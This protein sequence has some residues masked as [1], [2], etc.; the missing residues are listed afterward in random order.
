MRI[1]Y[2]SQYFPPEVGA[3]QI[4]AYEMAHNWVRLGHQVTMIA[5]IPNHPSGIIP[6]AYRGMLYQRENLDGIDVIRV[7]VRTSPVKNFLN[8]MLF[9]ITYMLTASAAGL[10]IARDH[11]DL[12]YASS[13]PLF[14]GG[15]ALFLSWA[16]RIPLVFEVRDLWPESAVVL[17]E[18]SNPRAVAWATRLEEAC[19]K[20]AKKIVVVSQEI[21]QR[22][23][24]RN[25]R[26]DKII[27]IPN[28]SDTEL[29]EFNLSERERLK[30][31][32][33]L[34]NKFLALYAGNHG[35]AYA[36]ET[37]IEAARILESN[38][39]FH[40]LLV[41][42]G[43]KKA[44]LATMVQEYR[45]SNVTM[46]PEQSRE[47]I[48]A[49]FSAADVV[50]IPVRNVNLLMLPVKIFD[51]WAC[52]RP[53]ILSFEGEARQIMEA[54]QAGVFVPPEDPDAL[55]KSLLALKAAPEDRKRM[56]EKGRAYTVQHHSRKALAEKLIK[57]LEK[58]D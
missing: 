38:P 55:A 14:V 36:L 16:R 37:L 46:L 20:R 21:R 49:F 15:A 30:A 23:V 44:A 28:G 18:L 2:L 50:I 26:E 19:Y 31:E 25:V 58:L 41:G 6:P 1:L 34:K 48:P 47:L 3:T 52:R 5:E 8:R 17:G 54:A 22:L 10:I 33:G 7:W 12:I 45:L 51:A 32:L 56:G 29:F 57:Q 42:E 27:L 43:P 39:S 53:I 13:P 40:F 11:Y 4:R 35:V 24:E 9:Y